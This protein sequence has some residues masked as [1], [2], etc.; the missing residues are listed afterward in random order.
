[1]SEWFVKR[2]G[3]AGG[4]MNAG[5]VSSSN[6]LSIQLI[7][8]I[9]TAIGGLVIPLALPPLLEKYGIAKTLRILAIVNIIVCIVCLPFL[10]GRLPETR[11]SGPAA[12]A[13][14]NRLWMK[15]GSFWA[16]NI[17]NT[18]QGFAYFVPLLWLPRT[19]D[20]LLRFSHGVTELHNRVRHIPPPE[21]PRRFSISRTIERSKHCRAAEPRDPFR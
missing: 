5:N 8:S 14:D 12:R 6:V 15:N 7:A 13:S 9:G 20:L 17:A 3:L 11:V 16:I 2:R 4:I 1:M 19:L 10:R 21:Y 18:L